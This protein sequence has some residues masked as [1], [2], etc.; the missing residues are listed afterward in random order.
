MTNLN[1]SLVRLW[2][3]SMK[4]LIVDDVIL[5]REL[6][7]S[8]LEEYAETIDMAENG[9]EAVKLFTQALNE[10]KPYNFICLDI[11]MPVMNGQE[12][13]KT[14]RA[15]ENE[16]GVKE[17]KESVI[18]MTTS[19]DSLEDIQKAIWQGDCNNYLVKPVSKADLIALLNKYKLID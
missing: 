14:M 4:C 10:G 18:I 3:F 16:F 5:G 13:L 6:L 7:S 1:H 2:G 15:L 17:G 8:F 12:A 11:L 9:E 19:L